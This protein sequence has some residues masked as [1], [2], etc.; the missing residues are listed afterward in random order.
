MHRWHTRAIQL[1]GSP[2][3][4]VQI[5]DVMVHPKQRG[6]L[7][8]KG[9]FFQAAANFLEHFVGQG[10]DFPIAFGFPSE[11]AYR[12]AEHLGL[13]EKVGELMRVS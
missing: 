7:T 12:L 10:K 3:R 6:I 4:A 11:R 2:A 5:G 8:R 9:P 13:Y 1:F